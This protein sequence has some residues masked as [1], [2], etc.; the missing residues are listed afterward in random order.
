MIR[1]LSCDFCAL[2]MIITYL[3][4]IS[5]R[6]FSLAY[7]LALRLKLQEEGP[8]N[9]IA[10]PCHLLP[11]TSISGP[12]YRSLTV[13]KPSIS[14]QHRL[15]VTMKFHLLFNLFCII[16]AIYRHFLIFYLLLQLFHMTL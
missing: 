11:T 1:G 8:D 15:S 13:Y 10:L 14:L 12:I 6:S 9:F 7:L 5:T 3:L 16:C 4:I 2:H